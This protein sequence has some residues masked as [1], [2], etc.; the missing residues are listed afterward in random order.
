MSKISLVSFSTLLN[1]LLPNLK[2]PSAVILDFLKK[3]CV[4]KIE[5]SLGTKPAFHLLDL[6]CIDNQL[7]I[8]I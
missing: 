6:M 2:S 8:N 1:I 4:L 3:S 5:L 7:V